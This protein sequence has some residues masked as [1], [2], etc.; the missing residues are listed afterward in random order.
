MSAPTLVD[1]DLTPDEIEILRCWRAMTV[2]I[3]IES[4]GVML[5]NAELCLRIKLP[6]PAPGLRLVSADGKAVGD[7]TD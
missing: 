7:E 2:R 6:A 5:R 1:A 3:K 4:L